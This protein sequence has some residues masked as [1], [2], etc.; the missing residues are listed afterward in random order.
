MNEL[1]PT[2]AFGE[3]LLDLIEAQYEGDFDA[4]IEAI[5]NTTGLSEEEVVAIVQGD[6]IV[7]D[8]SLLSEIVDAFP[9][10]DDN[11]LEV[12]VNVATGVE[13]ED[14][15]TLIGEIEANEGAME[16]GEM[17]MEQPAPSFSRFD[18]TA[19]FQAE[20]LSSRVNQLEQQLVEFQ[21][22]ND[23]SSKLKEIDAKTSAYVANEILPPSYKAMLIGNFANDDQRVAQFS[24]IAAENGVTVETMLF[25]TEYAMGLL[26]DASQFVEFKDY[27]MSDENLAVANFN[28]S[29]DSMVAADLEAIFDN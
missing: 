25:A 8:E 15:D 28:A 18:N 23:I 29:L 12:I 14:R 10:A 13:Q 16:E 3:L 4:G 21:M 2:N 22:Y 26:K 7:E 19:N 20:A 11:D 6:T 5:M 24:Q 1:N 27:S 17:P 9:D